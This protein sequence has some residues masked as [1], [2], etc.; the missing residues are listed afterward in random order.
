MRQKEAE[1]HGDKQVELVSARGSAF[2]PD[3]HHVHPFQLAAVEEV[4]I[5]AIGVGDAG[6]LRVDGRGSEGLV[7]EPVLVRLNTTRVAGRVVEHVVYS[8]HG[9]EH[10]KRAGAVRVAPRIE[11]QSLLWQRSI[12]PIV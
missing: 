8:A 12:G 3:G 9:I 5:R 1:D 11:A 7:L 6:T 4:H 2:L 10:G